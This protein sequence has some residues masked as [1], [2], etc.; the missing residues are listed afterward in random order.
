MHFLE[1]PNS[2]LASAEC[3]RVAESLHRYGVLILRDPRVDESENNTFL[4]LVERYF[5]QPDEIKD[6]DKRP[7]YHY[8]VISEYLNSFLLNK[9]LSYFFFFF[10]FKGG[11]DTRINRV[12]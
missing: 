10:Q 3:M 4:D 7:E 9:N 12:A 2:D 1:D 8:Q 5:E 6:L 11:C